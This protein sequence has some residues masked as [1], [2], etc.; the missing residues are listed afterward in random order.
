MSEEDQQKTFEAELQAYSSPWIRYFL[1]Y[2]PHDKLKTL[3]IPIF[4]LNGT[5]DCQVSCDEN[6]EG[7][8]KS[9]K[10]AKNSQ[11]K[12][13]KYEKLNH[14][15]QEAYTGAAMEYGMIE[16]TINPQ[17]LKDVTEWIIKL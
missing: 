1:N 13:K 9:L 2:N 5:L 14:L 11:Y 10:K 3:Q 16:E 7:I 4:A 15:L 12:I 8:E 17:V 6:L